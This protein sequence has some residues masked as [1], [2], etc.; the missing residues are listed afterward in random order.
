MISRQK[1]KGDLLETSN[2]EIIPY[3]GIHDAKIQISNVI[4][5]IARNILLGLDNIRTE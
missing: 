5:N 1:N 2:G 4:A 3:L